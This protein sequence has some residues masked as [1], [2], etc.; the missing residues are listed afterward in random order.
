MAN[1][2]NSDIVLNAKSPDLENL[3]LFSTLVNYFLEVYEGNR[4]ME[5]SMSTFPIVIQQ[6]AGETCQHAER[7]FVRAHVM[8]R[9]HRQR[10]SNNGHTKTTSTSASQV[11]VDPKDD[12]TLP[13]AARKGLVRPNQATFIEHTPA[14]ERTPTSRKRKQAD[15]KLPEGHL[16][17]ESQKPEAQVSVIKP[18]TSL[19]P[20]SI[21]DLHLADPR[22][23]Q[24][25][26]FKEVVNGCQSNISNDTS[27]IS[28]VI[29][30]SRISDV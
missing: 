27:A 10:K 1:L 4:N 8:E 28:R 26:I 18:R 7:T 5:T 13:V 11:F 19:L 23:Q 2:K 3:I 30:K 20:V 12:E 22:V 14:H 24:S 9:Y 6:N 25:M 17:K 29:W 21:N 15:K 16:L